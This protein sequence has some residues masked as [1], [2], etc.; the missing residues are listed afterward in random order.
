LAWDL[1]EKHDLW[2]VSV[3]PSGMIGPH[4]YG[5][6]TPTMGVISKFLTNKLPF[7]P[8]FNFNL[9]DIRD[10][11]DAMI[12]AAKKGKSGDRYILAQEHPISSTEVIA[13]AHSLYPGTKIPSKA[14][15]FLISILAFAIE[16]LSKITR[17]QPLML[18]SHV[19][20]FYKGDFRYNTSKA[21]TE[22]RFSPRPSKEALEAAFKYLA[23]QE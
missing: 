4:S 8:Q 1:A 14:P 11:A 7:D 21:R 18:R 12:T 6:L 9:V 3:L 16:Y 23:D 20:K 5:R 22:L 17:K 13:F 19:E 15:Y 2:M 10:V